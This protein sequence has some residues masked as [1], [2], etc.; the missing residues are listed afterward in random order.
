[1]HIIRCYGHD[2]ENLDAFS[3]GTNALR[4]GLQI[5]KKKSSFGQGPAK[6]ESVLETWRVDRRNL[7]GVL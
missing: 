3:S 1:M 2:F 5:Y 7:E 4:A 6:I